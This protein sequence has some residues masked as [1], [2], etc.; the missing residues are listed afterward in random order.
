MSYAIFKTGGKQFRA[1][2]GTTLR[3]PAA[4]QGPGAMPQSLVEKLDLVIAR[5]VVAPHAVGPRRDGPRR[6]LTIAQAPTL[7]VHRSR[8]HR[9]MPSIG[10]RWPRPGESHAPGVLRRASSLQENVVRRRR[11]RPGRGP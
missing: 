10:G 6:P 1:E 8:V 3:I 4:R 7:I 9:I 11:A 2:A 5:G